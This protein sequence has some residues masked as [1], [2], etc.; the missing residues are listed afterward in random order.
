VKISVIIPVRNEIEKLRKCVASLRY[1]SLQPNQ[2]I[3]VDDGSSPQIKADAFGSDISVINLPEQGG[4]A[5][6]RNIGAKSADGEIILFLDADIYVER[7]TLHKIE[8]LFSEQS[9][10]AVVGVFDDSKKYGSFFS[11]YKNLWMRYT[12]EKSAPRAALFY[13]SVAAIKKE[14]FT[15]TRGFD[16]RYIYPSIEDTVFGNQL[17][18]LG[19]RPL[20]SLDIKVFHDKEYS[21]SSI[22]KTD[23]LRSSDLVKMKLRKDVGNVLE[24]N[25]TSV[26][27]SFMISVAATMTFLLLSLITRNFALFACFMLAPAVLNL[28]FLWWLYRKRGLIFSLRSALFLPIDHLA[29]FSGIIHGLLSHFL[30]GIF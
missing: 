12:Y 29:V 3:V 13:T 26:P 22:L 30:S 5:H 14:V 23:L 25:R 16:E 27:V 20:I 17:W 9:E 10:D 15:A 2:I 21:F 1:S 7:D 6:A 28:N 19:K 11:D 24:G 4:P 8:R 18:D